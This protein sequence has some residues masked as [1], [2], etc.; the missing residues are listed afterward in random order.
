M[1]VPDLTDVPLGDLVSLRERTAVVT[2]GG[3]GIGRAICLRLAEAG[4]RVV[5]AD[6]DAGP[7][8]DVAREVADRG[9]TATARRLDVADSAD[10]AATADA[11]V[12]E[13]GGLDIWVNNAGIYP[14]RPLLEMSDEDW[15]RVLDV[16]LRGAFVG[17]RE[18]ARR[19]VAADRGGVIVNLASVAGFRGRRALAHYSSSKHALRG[20]TRS[21]A[22]E[23]GPHG[24]RALAVA[25]TMVATPGTEEATRQ[26]RPANAHPTSVYD[27]LPLG[28]PGLPDDIARVVLFCASDLAS[29]MT[30]STLVVDAG[31]MSL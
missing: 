14:A 19:M 6:R 25:P 2:G 23:L 9:G 21:L 5:V 26:V 4:A 24:I 8:G 1:P 13:H 7:A 27:N 28:R 16:N 15:D 30:G 18:A 20:L 22:V 12:D 17:A 10:I 3:R 29:Y 11:A 31:Q